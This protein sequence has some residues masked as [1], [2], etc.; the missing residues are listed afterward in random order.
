MPEVRAAC[1]DALTSF[2][3]TGDIDAATM[4]EEETLAS[5]VVAMGMDGSI[6]VRK[7]L[8][9]FYSTFIK[10]YEPRFIVAAWEQLS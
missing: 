9:V 3:A 1:L 7:E 6:M 5:V 2:V 4:L 8:V 10:R